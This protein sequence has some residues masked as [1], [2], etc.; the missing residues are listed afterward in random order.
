MVI[1][2][3]QN[4]SHRH[5]CYNSNIKYV[6][7]TI[8]YIGFESIH[9]IIN[10]DVVSSYFDSDCVASIDIGLELVGVAGPVRRAR[11]MHNLHRK[12]GPTGECRPPLRC[13][14]V[15]LVRRARSMY[16]LHIKGG[17][18]GECRSP[19]RCL[20]QFISYDKERGQLLM[21]L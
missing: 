21:V 3:L 9:Y 1:N 4:Y 12:G 5:Y 8:K 11:S 14:V 15:G 7:S 16:N 13:L 6:G 18:T 2:M 20:S 19:L 17:P 10:M